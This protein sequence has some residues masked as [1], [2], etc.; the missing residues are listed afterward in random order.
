MSNETQ[1]ITKT[2]DS[3]IT[4]VISA[5]TLEGFAK[6]ELY[7]EAIGALNIAIDD[8][9]MRKIMPL[10]GNKLGF[11]T[12]KETSGGYSQDIVK[13]CLIEAVLI[14]A[15]PWGNQFNIIAGNMYVTKE[16]FKYLLD[17]IPGLKWEITPG[18]PRINAEKTSG[19]VIMTAEWTMGANAK[20][21]RSWEIAVKMNNFMGA[22]AVIGK[23]E[24]KA[25]KRLYELVSGV[26]V[27]DGDIGDIPAGESSETMMWK[28][29]LKDVTTI[30]A[31]DNL[32][33]ENKE[34]IA[35]SPELTALFVKKRNELKKPTA[36]DKASAATRQA[37][38]GL[39]K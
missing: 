1:A 14:G 16:G 12:D 8:T 36:K 38:A 27:G 25:R 3:A 22:D 35:A 2:I 34:Q 10:Q 4:K 39:F 17:N 28:E 5:R 24:R 23:A 32:E 13:R 7:A 33:N 29:L 20:E 37:E 19:A 30:E 9:Y 18:L 26:E 31:L 15:Q 21:S 11:R 6:A